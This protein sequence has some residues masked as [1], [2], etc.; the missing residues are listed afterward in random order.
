MIEPSDD[1]KLVLGI[2]SGTSADAVDIALIKIK[3]GE[4][5]QLNVEKFDSYPINKELK[6]YLLLCSSK[7]KIQTDL[8]CKLNFAVGNL[9]SDCILS[10]FT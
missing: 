5:L 3:G 7:D 1:E 4:K 9:F 10:F 2:L 6:D 8:I